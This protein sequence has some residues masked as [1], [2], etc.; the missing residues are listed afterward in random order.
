MPLYNYKG[1]DAA[2]GAL[3]KGKIEAES[4]KAARTRLR[5]KDKIVVS[6][7]KEEASLDKARSKAKFSFDN[8]VKLGE[9]SVMSRQ[10]AVLQ[11]AHVPLDESLR[12]LTQQHQQLGQFG[13]DNP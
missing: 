12:A 4:P 6:E 2:T 9:I 1:Y 5:Q 7:M 8:K 11:N 10:F 3:K 13:L